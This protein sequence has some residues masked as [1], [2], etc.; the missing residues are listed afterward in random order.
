MN[1]NNSNKMYG[2][3]EG[4]TIF[5]DERVDEINDRMMSRNRTTDDLKP[6]ISVRP[7][8]T[9]YAHFPVVKN[10]PKSRVPFK[11]ARRFSTKDAYNPGNSKSP[12]EG[13]S[14]NINTESTLR[15]QFFAL[16]SSDRHE[17]VPD[18]TS[19]LYNEYTPTFGTPMQTHA[20]LNR[21]DDFDTVNP[22]S[23]NLGW[24]TFNNNTRIQLQDVFDTDTN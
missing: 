24:Q 12:W 14:D 4:V 15:S 5:N 9:K 17:Y 10:I 1:V 18:S 20:S 3:V 8:S 2:V 16:Q 11:S 7:S 23:Y 21:E 6:N 19:Q 13:F 22:N